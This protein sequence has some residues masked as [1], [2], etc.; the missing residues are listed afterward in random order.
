MVP[1][2]MEGLVARGFHCTEKASKFLFYCLWQYGAH[3]GEDAK[4][5]CYVSQ[6]VFYLPMN[7]VCNWSTYRSCSG[8]TGLHFVCAHYNINLGPHILVV[9][10]NNSIADAI[11][12][13]SMLVSSS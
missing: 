5:V 1:V 8:M 3:F 6:P 4:S 7:I 11:S 13:N 10:V 9:G 12:W 2:C